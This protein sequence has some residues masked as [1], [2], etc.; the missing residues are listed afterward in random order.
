MRRH[1]S[2]LVFVP[3]LVAA[4]FAHSPPAWAVAQRTFVSPPTD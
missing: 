3:A 1:F 4:A 2:S